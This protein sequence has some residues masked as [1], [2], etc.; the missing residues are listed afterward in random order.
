MFDFLDARRTNEDFPLPNFLDTVFK[1]R[2]SIPAYSWK[3]IPEVV[4]SN[5]TEA[6]NVMLSRCTSDMAHLFI[7][8]TYKD[9]V[10]QEFNICCEI[11]GGEARLSQLQEGY[12][13]FA[14]AGYCS[15]RRHGNGSG[16]TY[17]TFLISPPHHVHQSPSLVV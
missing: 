13:N 14:T 6:N 3:R 9:S 15:F 10:L 1:L 7:A 4:S 2:C 8:L 17:S 11:I 12:S 5:K 16:C